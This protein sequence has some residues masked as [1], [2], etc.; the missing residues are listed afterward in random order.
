MRDAVLEETLKDRQ[1]RCWVTPKHLRGWLIIEYELS[2]EEG[3][4]LQVCPAGSRA[5]GG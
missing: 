2:E 1:I 5:E 3:E 4:R